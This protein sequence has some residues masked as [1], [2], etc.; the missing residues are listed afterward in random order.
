[1][2]SDIEFYLP[3]TTGQHEEINGK[4][5][6][7]NQ[8]DKGKEMVFKF[9]GDDDVWVLVDNSL[10]LDMG[11]IHGKVYGEINLSRGTT[12]VAQGGTTK[13]LDDDKIMSY[14]TG[15]TVTPDTITLGPGKH[16]LTICYLERGSS[17]SNCA[18][19]FNISPEYA[20]DLDKNDSD[21]TSAKLRNAE[22]Q[23]F[24]DPACETPAEEFA[25]NGV[26]KTYTTGEQGN[27]HINGFHAG[28]TY[29]LKETKAPEGY[30]DVSAKVITLAFGNTGV[31]R[32]YSPT[33]MLRP[34]S[35]GVPN[36]AGE[37]DANYKWY[38]LGIPNKRVSVSVEKKWQGTSATDGASVGVSLHRHSYKDRGTPE[39]THTVSVQAAYL[40]GDNQK[41]VYSCDKMKSVS[42]LQ[43]IASFTVGDGDTV[44]FDVLA[45]HYDG[46]LAIYPYE[47]Y[48]PYK[49][50]IKT[51]SQYFGVKKEGSTVRQQLPYHVT[52]EV[53]NITA[54]VVVKVYLIGDGGSAS[55]FTRYLTVSMPTYTTSDDAL[56]G[57]M[58]D[59]QVVG[60][61]TLTASNSWKYEWTGLPDKDPATGNLY[62]YYVTE[63]NV[64][65]GEKDI[66]SFYTDIY[67]P[68]RVDHGKITLTNEYGLVPVKLRKRDADDHN[69]KLGGAQFKLYTSYDVTNKTGTLFNVE[70][71]YLDVTSTWNSEGKYFTSREDDGNFYVGLLPIGTYYLVEIAAPS[72]YNLL[73]GPVELVVE[74][75]RVGYKMPGADSYS[76]QAVESSGAMKYINIYID[77]TPGYTLPS[78]GGPGTVIYMVAGL[79]LIA[80]A[81]ALLLRRRREY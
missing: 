21:D 59:D 64:K 24:S 49:T 57:R 71:D 44:S 34:L 27:V 65:V 42:A 60:T 48:T 20:I 62:Y 81:M 19:Y 14:G 8:S 11:G 74:P 72:G 23:I 70:T 77:N 17:Q 7:G 80:L 50:F 63:D 45:N 76:Y 1:M 73:N 46:A 61:Q 40:M 54:D 9:C 69:N 47:G 66:T 39:S 10:V 15:G 31:L 25:E 41:A 18:I 33:D 6:Y 68:K 2:K 37:N 5:V 13:V 26:A 51:S 22:F 78:T 32:V 16:T 29:Y 4:T 79:G 56:L 52:Y 28:R 35:I 55:S 67:N 3:N 30:P 58:S 36:P 43:D 38:R 12:A 53:S 75:G